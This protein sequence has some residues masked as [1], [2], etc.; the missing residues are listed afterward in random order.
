[1]CVCVHM[2]VAEGPESGLA[3]WFS[4][5]GMTW[6]RIPLR[7]SGPGHK[8]P[9]SPAGGTGLFLKLVGAV[10]GIMQRWLWLDFGGQ[11]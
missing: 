8:G 10:R 5:E 3:E 2:H 1:M 4:M 9:Q 7:L 6:E 11:T